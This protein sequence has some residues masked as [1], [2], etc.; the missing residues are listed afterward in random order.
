MTARQPHMSPSSRLILHMTFLPSLNT[1]YKQR[2]Q[3]LG[4][5]GCWECQAYGL[6]DHFG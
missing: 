5:E 6:T 1:K 4:K 2:L 3:S